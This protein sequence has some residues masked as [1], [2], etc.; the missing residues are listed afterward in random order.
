MIKPYYEEPNITIYNNDCLEVMREIPDNSIDM[1]FTSPPFKNEDVQENYWQIYKKWYLEMIRVAS[2]VICIIHSATKINEL[3]KNYP[4]DRLMIYDKGFSSYTYRFNPIFIYSKNG[5]KVNK[6][7]WTDILRGNLPIIKKR[8]HKYQDSIKPYR[9]TIKM[10]KDCALVL[11]PFLGSGTTARA[12]KDLGRKCIGIEI[13]QKYC[14]IAI[15]RLGQE[16][17]DLNG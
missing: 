6:Y 10:F 9:I 4:P 1:I 5:Y 14:D 16:V 15:K 11:D 3:I 13:S 7:I 12:C 8:L 2:K 17:L